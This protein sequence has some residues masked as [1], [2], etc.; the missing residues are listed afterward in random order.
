MAQKE[1]EKSPSPTFIFMLFSKN[2][3]VRLEIEDSG[4]GIDVETRRKVFEPFF[5]IK[6]VGVGNGLGLSV[7]YFIITE[8][9]K[10]KMGVVALLGKGSLFY[11]ELPV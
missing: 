9:H 4:P 8:N 7:S 6:A 5:T 2:K 3:M 10:G 1:Y 11:I